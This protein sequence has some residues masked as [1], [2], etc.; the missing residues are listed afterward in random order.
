MTI[1]VDLG[2]KATKPTNQPTI[3]ASVSYR[4]RC[5]V[6]VLRRGLLFVCV[7]FLLLFFVIFFE[8]TIPL[9]GLLIKRHRFWAATVGCTGNS[10]TQYGTIGY[11]HLCN[12]PLR[13]ARIWGV[14][15]LPRSVFEFLAF[16]AFY[17]FKEVWY[18]VKKACYAGAYCNWG[19]SFVKRNFYFIVRRVYVRY[20]K[21]RVFLAQTCVLKFFLLKFGQLH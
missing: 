17:Y 1:A 6:L 21:F 12:A 15:E 9:L 3:F 7:V 8:Q 11:N 14:F 19:D 10:R 5:F 16:L 4:R 2:R 13:S 20:A 18:N